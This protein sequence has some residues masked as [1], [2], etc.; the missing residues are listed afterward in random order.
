MYM[1]HLQRQSSWFEAASTDAHN[2]ESG[3]QRFNDLEDNQRKRT[4][5]D[6]P[7]ENASGHHQNTEEDRLIEH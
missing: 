7:A 2:E 3:Y 5:T 4:L 6:T 1:T